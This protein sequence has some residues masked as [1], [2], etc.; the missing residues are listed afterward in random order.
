MNV[1]SLINRKTS[2]KEQNMKDLIPS[3]FKITQLASRFAIL[4]MLALSAP[5]Y[6]EEEHGGE[7]GEEEGDAIELDAAEQKAAGIVTE[8]IHNAPLNELITVP[9]EIM[10]N[11]YNTSRVTP[12]ITAQVVER[13]ARLGD[14]VKSGSPLVTLSSVAMAQAQGT[15]IVA[16]REWQRVKKLGKSAVSAKRYT[17]AQV[18][19]QLALSRVLAY[20]MG[21]SQ[22]N[23]LVGSGNAS[24]ATGEFGLLAPQNGTVLADDFI[25]GE[26]IDPG[27]ILF[28][29]SNE[30]SLWVEA[31]M[32]ASQ[33]DNVNIGNVAQVSVNK[34]SW[35]TGKIVQIHHRLDETTR[36]QGLRIEIPNLNDSFHPGQFAEAR[37]TTGHSTPVLSVP[38]D[39]M[40]LINGSSTIFLLEDGHEFH[41]QAIET[42]ETMGDRTVVLSGL[43]V[44]DIVAIKGVF[45]LKSMMLKSTLGEGH[46]H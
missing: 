36:T 34:N 17:E 22:A 25:V 27:R 40:T 43:S 35:V 8:T 16:A 2:E 6:A 31:K 20:G 21:Q 19:Q 46:G 7:H 14:S 42:G 18:A 4:L 15:L 5:S 9:A 10:L 24:L 1:S 39:S 11:A 44:G 26:L 29:I 28:T 38:S 33:L 23:K 3:L 45:Y 12:R 13:H 41:P 37:V 32:L 30:S